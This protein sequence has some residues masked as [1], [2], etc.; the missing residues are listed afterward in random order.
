MGTG[1]KKGTLHLRRGAF[2]DEIDLDATLENIVA[3]PLEDIEEN[4]ATWDRKREEQGFVIMFDH[5]YSMRGP[6]I[7]LAALTVAAIAIYFKRNYGVV[8]FNSDIQTVK[9]VRDA[10][11]HEVLLDKVFDLPIE[12]LTSISGAL[13]TGLTQLHDFNKRFGLLPDRR[14][15][16][17]GRGSAAG[18]GE[19]QQAERYRLPAGQPG[20]GAAVGRGRAR[21]VPGTPT[22][23][24]P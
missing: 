21:H 2:S 16:D 1:V 6:K 4:L 15:L 22:T 11:H 20:Q 23:R 18:G 19:V 5:S 12:G 3:N 10:M 24:T 13:L 17:L 9:D 8:G 7:V 14:G